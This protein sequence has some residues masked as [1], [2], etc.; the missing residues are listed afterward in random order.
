[1][2]SLSRVLVIESL[3]RNTQSAYFSEVGI[4]YRLSTFGLYAQLPQP[5][6]F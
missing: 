3:D 1:M 6:L 5:E 4:P 2:S